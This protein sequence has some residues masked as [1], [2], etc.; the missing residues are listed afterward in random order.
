ME[1]F[2]PI[3]TLNIDSPSTYCVKN[4]NGQ[5]QCIY[6]MDGG[7]GTEK[8]NHPQTPID[9]PRGL[10]KQV[11]IDVDWMD[12]DF[13]K[14]LPFKPHDQTSNQ[15]WTGMQLQHAS[16]SEALAAAASES[17]AG[18]WLSIYTK[19]VRPVVLSKFRQSDLNI[20]G[21]LYVPE[22]S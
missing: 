3:F 9:G 6:D 10:R 16:N 5:Q 15:L 19:M 7:A 11:N 18:G 21:G 17:P 13:I 12:P 4:Q 20:K 8:Y 2:N 14:S 22:E 1:T